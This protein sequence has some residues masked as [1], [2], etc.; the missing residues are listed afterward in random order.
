[1]KYMK[2]II[3]ILKDLLLSG[4]IIKNKRALER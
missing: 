3:Q 2:V 4:L 1:M